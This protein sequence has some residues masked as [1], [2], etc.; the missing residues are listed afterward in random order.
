MHFASANPLAPRQLCLALALTLAVTLTPALTVRADGI[1]HVVQPGENLFRIGLSYGVS[2]RDLMAANRLQSTT[3]RPGQVLIIPSGASVTGIPRAANTGGAATPSAPTA[4]ATPAPAAA[5]SSVYIVQRG[6]TL[7]FVA[8]RYHLSV[9]E[10]MQA[11]RLAN[12]NLVYAG[13]ALSLPSATGH[14]L[15]VTGHPQALPL[16][17]ESRSAADWAGYFGVTIDELE[18]FNRLPLSDDPDAGFVGN[19]LGAWGQTP[20]NAYGVNAGPIASLLRAYGVNARAASGL[21][22]DTLQ[23]EIDHDR[24]VIVWVV[25]HAAYGVGFPSTAASDAHTTLVARYEHTLL[26]TGYGRD[27]VTLLDGAMSY[28]RPLA[29]FLASWGALDSQAVLAQ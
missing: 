8:Q 4:T 3:I 12:P 20:P 13:Q 28:T 15:A 16:D 21:D 18:F 27:T 24:P 2:W 23:A 6:D 9:A 5:S 19:V 1:T 14:W 10:L 7:N 29:Q 25:G 26:V 17:C 22:W 11:N